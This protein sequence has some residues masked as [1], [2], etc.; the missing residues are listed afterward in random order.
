MEEQEAM[1]VA[2][3]ATAQAIPEVMKAVKPKAAAPKAADPLKIVKADLAAAKKEI[4]R[5]EADMVALSEELQGQR[6]KNEILFRDT[7]QAKQALNELEQKQAMAINQ[8]T[9][10]LQMLGNDVIIMLNK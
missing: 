1:A 5:L 2:V 6:T 4:A 7:Q 10:K 3:E 9:Q 8:I